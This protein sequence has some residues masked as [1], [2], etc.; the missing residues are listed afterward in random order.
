MELDTLVRKR[1]TVKFKLTSFIKYFEAL[2]VRLT[3][4][5]ESKD[6]IE[7]QIRVEKLELLYD[8]FEA[9]QS[10]IELVCFLADLDK[11]FEERNS[12]NDLHS[13]ILAK[14]KEVL[15]RYDYDSKSSDGCVGSGIIHN[16]LSNPVVSDAFGAVKLPP[17]KCPTFNCEFN[18]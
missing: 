6:I 16:N 13:D 1:G 15:K 9:V 4:Q 11:Q 5:Q 2:S 10:D 14:A 18:N 12:F 7:L 8:E 3:D 17:I